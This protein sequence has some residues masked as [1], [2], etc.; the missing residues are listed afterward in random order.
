MLTLLIGNKNYSSWSLRAWLALKG[1]DIAF[2]ERLIPFGSPAFTTALE[3]LGSP[4][5]VPLLLDG[6]VPVWDSL[7]IIEHVAERYPDKPIWPG[8]REARAL[9]RAIS[10]EMHSGFPRLRAH[11]P[12]N[13]WRPAESRAYGPEVGAEIDRVCAIWE[14]ARTRFGADGPYLFGRFSAAD[15]M[16]APVAT[17]LRTYGVPLAPQAHAYVE[18]IHADPHFAAW[19]AEALKEPWV[20]PHD[21]P[22]W[23]EVKRVSAP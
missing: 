5:R 20:E 10:A 14:Q 21:E 19:K 3:G 9:A 7:A 13:L 2:E 18:A 17:R 23:P 22:D 12:M 1:A 15:A 4:M 8:G 6:G 16:Y 11:F